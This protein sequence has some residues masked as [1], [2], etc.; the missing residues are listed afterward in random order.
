MVVTRVTFEFFRRDTNGITARKERE[1]T[2][3]LFGIPR[4]EVVTSDGKTVEKSFEML[5]LVEM[6][7]TPK[8]VAEYDYHSASC[9]E[10]E[11]ADD[12]FD[13]DEGDEYEDCELDGECEED[14]ECEDE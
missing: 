9:A 7:M 6:G 12:F 1:E 11:V 5:L 8:D 2:V 10:Y 14:D 4:A 13:E 3:D